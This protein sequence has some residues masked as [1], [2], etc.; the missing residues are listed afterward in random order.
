[1]TNLTPEDQKRVEELQ[2]L[3]PEVGF[4]FCQGHGFDIDKYVTTLLTQKNAE[5]EAAVRAERER[6]KESLNWRG[7]EFHSGSQV[8]D[9]IDQQ[10]EALTQDPT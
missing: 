10:L 7:K 3:Y 1:M 5:I 6:I 8:V 9:W 4:E 2:K